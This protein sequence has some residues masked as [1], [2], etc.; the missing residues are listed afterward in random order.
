MAA[1]NSFNIL[2]LLLQARFT[3]AFTQV[4]RKG[5]QIRAM[6]H[7]SDLCATLPLLSGKEKV[8]IWS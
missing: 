6:A 5:Q 1:T 2:V 8:G 3:T 4:K 7:R